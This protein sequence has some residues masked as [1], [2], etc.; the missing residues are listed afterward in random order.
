MNGRLEQGI[1]LEG[2]GL[3]IMADTMVVGG[4]G[5]GMSRVWTRVLKSSLV[6]F[7]TIT[8]LCVSYP[9]IKESPPD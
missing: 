7:E 8:F 6:H 4:E 2:V 1:M 5:P 3:K 9:V